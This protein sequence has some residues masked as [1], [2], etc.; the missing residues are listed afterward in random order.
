M[1][2]RDR[3]CLPVVVCG[4][5]HAGGSPCLYVRRACHYAL[6]FRLFRLHTCYKLF[7][8]GEKVAIAFLF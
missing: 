4:F 7:G 5:G 3:V 2:S 8:Q 6:A 1:A